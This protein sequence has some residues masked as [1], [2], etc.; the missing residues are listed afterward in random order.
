MV[1]YVYPKGH[2]REGEVRP[3]IVVQNWGAEGDPTP[4]LNLNVIIDPANDPELAGN[5]QCS[6]EYSEEKKFR[7]WH[8]PELD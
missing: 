6:V 2:M 1:R 4:C 5:E 7:S 8:W 3:A